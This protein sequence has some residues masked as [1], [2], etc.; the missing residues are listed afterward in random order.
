MANSVH[1][2]KPGEPAG[3]WDFLTHALGVSR[4]AAKRLL[5]DRVVFVNGR[6]VWMAKHA[7]RPGDRVEVAGAAGSPAPPPEAPIPVLWQ[8]DAVVV[9]DKPAGCLSNEGPDSV[10]ARLRKQLG[11]PELVAVHR[12][13]RD[14]SGCLLLADGPEIEAA[15][16]AQFRGREVDKLY[17]V[18]VVGVFPAGVTLMDDPVD[19]RPARSRARCLAAGER[20]S[21]LE[22]RIE[23]GRTH[24]IRKHLWARRFPVAGDKQYG[25]AQELPPDFRHVPRQMLHAAELTLAHPLT[26]AP[27]KATAPLPADYRLWRRKLGLGS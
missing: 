16:I 6:R 17:R 18:L 20:A 24:Q 15:L 8:D 4:R 3:L 14:T 27:V 7:L 19:G 23:T 26:G 2:V 22:V 13:D 25:G 21:E 10:E 1:T 9:V 11:R 5:D 12:L